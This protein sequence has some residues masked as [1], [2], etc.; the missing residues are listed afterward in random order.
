VA[1]RPL[2]AAELPSND[3]LAVGSFGCC[4]VKMIPDPAR[5]LSQTMRSRGHRDAPK[6]TAST[7]PRQ[8]R[9]PLRIGEVGHGRRTA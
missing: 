8:E 9:I 3:P 5:E 4:R 2:D 7:G 6:A 1:Q